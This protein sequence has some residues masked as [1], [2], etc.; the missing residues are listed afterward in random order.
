MLSFFL[1]IRA[2]ISINNRRWLVVNHPAMPAVHLAYRF[3]VHPS[4]VVLSAVFHLHCGRRYLLV[5][6]PTVRNRLI[7]RK[8]LIDRGQRFAF[9]G[10]ITRGR[11]GGCLGGCCTAAVQFQFQWKGIL[12]PLEFAEGVTRT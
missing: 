12:Q 5:G 6:E 8:C 9:L 4:S 10:V 1:A 7:S 3:D 2:I 11:G